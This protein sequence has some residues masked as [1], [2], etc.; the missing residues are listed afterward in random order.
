MERKIKGG[1]GSI[2]LM[3]LVLA[4][5]GVHAQ[6]TYA[7]WGGCYNNCFINTKRTQTESL[8][9]D[10]QCLNSCI[11]HSAADFKYYCQIGCS[12]KLCI[13]VSYDSARLEKCFGKCTKL[14]KKS[15]LP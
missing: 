13:P 2:I 11:P 7:C 14:C 3:V 9:C 15:L 1:A 8:A 10:Y 12:L 4:N 5:I 6:N